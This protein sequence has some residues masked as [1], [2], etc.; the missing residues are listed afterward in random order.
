V[1]DRN[2][3]LGDPVDSLPLRSARVALE[4]GIRTA[5]KLYHFT[6]EE[7]G[8][9]GLGDGDTLILP[10]SNGLVWLTDLPLPMRKQLG[11]TGYD[12]DRGAARYEVTEIKAQGIHPW[13]EVRE[14]LPLEAVAAVELREG[15]MVMRWY[16]SSGP[17]SA[18]F[19]PIEG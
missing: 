12:C 6:C 7:H 1:V 13:H 8:R 9:R 10:G 3:V 17:V 18:R 14:K 16:V 11:L 5:V 2:L 15:I 4:M 19:S